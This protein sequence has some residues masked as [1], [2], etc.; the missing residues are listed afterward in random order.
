MRERR[1]NDKEKTA[2]TTNLTGAA[3]YRGEVQPCLCFSSLGNPLANE[4]MKQI[5]Q[6][7]NSLSSQ[8]KDS[9]PGFC[10]R[11]RRQ[12]PSYTGT[13]R[14]SET[15]GWEGLGRYEL[16]TR[17]P[18]PG[19]GSASEEVFGLSRTKGWALTGSVDG[20]LQKPRPRSLPGG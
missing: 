16:G 1:P 2:N 12:T 7:I 13:E 10:P 3:G 6:D 4:E 8:N 11:F 19:A 17:N 20:G 5:F 15:G 14:E 18:G 9:V